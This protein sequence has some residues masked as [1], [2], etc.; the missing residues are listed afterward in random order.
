M[1]GSNSSAPTTA[2]SNGACGTASGSNTY[3]Y[4]AASLCSAGTASGTDLSGTDGAYDWSC[5]G[6]GGGSPASCSAPKV[7]YGS[8][9][10]LL[11]GVPGTPSGTYS[12]DPDGVGGNPAYQAYCDMATDGGGWT[13]AIRLNTNDAT[14][15]KWDDTAF[16]NSTAEIGALSG[17][18]DY[19]SK[20]V[21]LVPKDVLLKY[22]Y[23]NNLTDGTWAVF[24]NASNASTLNANLNLSLSNT[25]PGWARQ[26]YSS[27]NAVTT[28]FFGS[29]MQ[30]ETLGNDS[31][32]SRI[33]YNSTNSVGACNQGG[34]IGHIGD[35]GTNNWNWEV[36]RGWPDASAGS[37]C[38]HNSLKLGLGANYDPV[39]WGTTAVTPSDLYS[40]GTMY[41]MVR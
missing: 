24:R 41:V 27:A 3:D 12:I 26:S 18:G 6:V 8:C 34:S 25:N 35:Y 15:R 22:V 9:F 30:F 36:A 19:L 28:D 5:L 17:T 37:G 32:R 40:Q 31:D 21:S 10:A 20:S 38:Q 29:T 1:D 2:V 4:P 33:F 23:Q 11:S 16:W 39:S 13:L 7:Y 14:K